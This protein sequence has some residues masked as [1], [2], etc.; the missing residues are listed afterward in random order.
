MKITPT[1]PSP[2]EEEGII[3]LFLSLDQREAP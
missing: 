3:E 2:V 1:I